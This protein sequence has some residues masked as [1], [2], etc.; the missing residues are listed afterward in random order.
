MNLSV[1]CS[2][3]KKLI[4]C[5]IVA[6]LC[7]IMFIWLDEVIDI[8]H[9]LLGAES[10]PL[11]WRES[12]SESMIVAI[13]GVLIISYTKKLIRRVKILEGFLPICSSCKRIRDSKG[14]W[15]QMESYIRDKSE[16]EF[17]HG[18]CPDCADKLASRLH[19]DF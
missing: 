19:K 13:I 7:I 12:L 5:E 2:F 6:F 18:L 4:T 9:L 1:R 10:T 11:N 3:R 17:T 8:P 15:H 16:A 14:H